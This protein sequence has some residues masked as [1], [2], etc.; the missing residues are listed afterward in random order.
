MNKAE[1]AIKF[2]Q[3]GDTEQHI[4]GMGLSRLKFV[5][6]VGVNGESL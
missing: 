3:F 4:G 2:Q 5:R 6:N 1:N